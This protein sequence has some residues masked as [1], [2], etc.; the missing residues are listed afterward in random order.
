[1][2][3]VVGEA[4]PIEA[5]CAKYE[6][7]FERVPSKQQIDGCPHTDVDQAIPSHLIKNDVSDLWA[8]VSV[9]L[10]DAQILSLQ[11]VLSRQVDFSNDESVYRFVESRCLCVI[12]GGHI[13]MVVHDMFVFELH[14]VNWN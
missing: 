14:V 9:L 3:D 4:F 1:M 6:V 8:V 12:E 7:E 10:L 2:G 5:P 13:L 11:G